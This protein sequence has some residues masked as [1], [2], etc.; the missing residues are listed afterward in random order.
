MQ[1]KEIEKSENI[2]SSNK[3]GTEIPNDKDNIFQTPCI[4]FGHLIR[5]ERDTVL[6]GYFLLP[7]VFR[8]VT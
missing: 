4:L 6:Q 3:S 2:F 7:P 8:T 5:N 1:G